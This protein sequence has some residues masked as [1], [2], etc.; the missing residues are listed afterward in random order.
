MYILKDSPYR[1]PVVGFRQFWSVSFHIDINEFYF[2]SFSQY[3][4]TQIVTE[5]CCAPNRKCD[6]ASELFPKVNRPNIVRPSDLFTTNLDKMSHHLAG[7][8]FWVYLSHFPLQK[9]RSDVENL[10]VWYMGWLKKNISLACWVINMQLPAICSIWMARGQ[11]WM[12]C[13][14]FTKNIYIQ[15]FNFTLNLLI[16]SHFN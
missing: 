11:R 15:I 7:N 1:Y 4:S 6:I 13:H 5:Y 14:A 8:V 3:S 10:R 12:I 16:L 2:P 9:G